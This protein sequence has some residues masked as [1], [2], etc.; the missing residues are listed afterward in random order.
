[1]TISKMDFFWS[2]WNLSV[3]LI[4]EK[5]V[6]REAPFDSFYLPASVFSAPKNFQFPTP[7]THEDD[8]QDQH[9][10]VALN[11]SFSGWDL[12]LYHAKVLDQRWHFTDSRTERFYG[13][14]TMSGLAATIA[15]GNILWKIEG[16][17]LENLKYNNVAEEK[18]RFDALLGLDYSGLTDTMISL[19]IANRHLYEYDDKLRKVPDL[20]REDEWQRAIRIQHSMD[21]E[22]LKLNYLYSIFGA[23]GQDGGFQRLW[24]EYA[25]VDDIII[26]I[27][28][29]D[30][31]GGEHKFRDAIS[32][33]DRLFA[34]IQY[35]F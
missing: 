14:I 12:S 31:T 32:D 20:I 19:E 26:S 4:H 25:V 5:R 21:H 13:S 17:Y 10:A 11:G 3:M 2:D 22:K 6:Q 7:K 30:Y 35:S 33:N 23:R 1:M 28:A 9:Y 18:S 24:S 27:G 16:A 15:S 8:N 29:I 34:D